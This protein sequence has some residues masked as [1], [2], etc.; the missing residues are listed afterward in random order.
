MTRSQPADAS[1]LEDPVEALRQTGEKLPRA[2]RERILA[3]G[4]AA[5]AALV[6]VLE[7]DELGLE[8]SPAG[9]WPPIHAVDLLVEL[10]AEESIAPMLAI[11]RDGELDEI[12]YSRIAVLLPSLGALV[13]EPLL[14]ELASP[15]DADHAGT[16]CSI[17]S[18]LGVRDERVWSELERYFAEE[19]L[20]AAYALAR[21]G[22]ER[23]LVLLDREIRDLASEPDDLPSRFELRELADAYERIAG[24]LPDDLSEIVDAL[25]K[26]AAG[27]DE[28]AT[29]PVLAVST[30]IGRNEPCPC[31]SGRKYKRCCLG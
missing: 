4:A 26:Q 29:A 2:L 14:S 28:L 3:Q 15:L 11:L 10:R 16:L 18:E 13:L 6:R 12:L 9:G 25:T 17:L 8:D 22:D 24:V 27:L 1:G 31:G 21:Y 20:S 7:D 23:A 19:P 30:K 5:V